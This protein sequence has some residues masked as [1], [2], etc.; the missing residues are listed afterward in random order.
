MPKVFDKGIREDICAEVSKGKSLVK[1]CEMPGMPNPKTVYE[2]LRDDEGFSNN[3]ARAK[4]E[5]AERHF[6]ECLE[7]ADAATAETVQKDRLRID[8]RKWMLGKMAPKSYGDRLDLTSTD[9]SMTPQQTIYQLPSN[10]R[11]ADDI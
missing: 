6:E 5:R 1:V 10:G 11:E 7:I 4:D 9:G 2:W 3:Y 8:T